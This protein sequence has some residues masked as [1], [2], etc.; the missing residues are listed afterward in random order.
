[1]SA[2]GHAESAG[3]RHLLDDC[4]GRQ[5][6][7]SPTSARRAHQKRSEP[8]PGSDAK[9]AGNYSPDWGTGPQRARRSPCIVARSGDSRSSTQTRDDVAPARAVYARSLND[10]QTCSVVCA[11]AFATTA[12][13]ISAKTRA[14]RTLRK[15]SP[16][17]IG[18]DADVFAV[19]LITNQERNACFG[20]RH[21]HHW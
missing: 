1:M 10:C 12:N 20:L 5:V 21:R 4:E 15:I 11:P 18:E 13:S 6:L 14:C 17:R 9:A 8:I 3:R 2:L 7:S 16:V 19:T